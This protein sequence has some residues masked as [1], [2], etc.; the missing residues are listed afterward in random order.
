MSES[1]T[2]HETVAQNNTERVWIVVEELEMR[3]RIRHVFDTEIMADEYIDR[4]ENVG[5]LFVEEH[6]VVSE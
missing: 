4:E 6:S 3:T 1:T 2:E 5:A